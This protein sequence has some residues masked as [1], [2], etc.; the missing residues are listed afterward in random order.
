VDASLTVGLD[1]IASGLLAGSIV[2]D[3]PCWWN[4]DHSYCTESNTYYKQL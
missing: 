1:L 2:T 3:K 4:I